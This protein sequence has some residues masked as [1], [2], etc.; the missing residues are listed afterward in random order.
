V[1]EAL[2][3][4]VWA[5][6]FWICFFL[7]GA[8]VAEAKGEEPLLNKRGEALVGR[9]NLNEATAAQLSELP[10]IGPVLAE[11]IIQWRQKKP[12]K[13]IEDLLRVKGVGRKRFIKWKSFLHTD[14]PTELR[15]QPRE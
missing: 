12:F 4:K 15:W 5:K 13:R 11:R 10:G 1:K 2:L 3:K 6:K 8:G 9:L 14:G 7:L